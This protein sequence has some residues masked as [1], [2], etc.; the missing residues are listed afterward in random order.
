VSSTAVLS[1]SIRQR[2]DRS[3]RLGL[4]IYARSQEYSELAGVDALL[5]LCFSPKGEYYTGRENAQT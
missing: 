1:W 5:T 4:Q 3:L 2:P